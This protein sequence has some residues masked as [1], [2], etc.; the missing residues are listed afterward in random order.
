MLSDPEDEEDDSQ[1]LLK[2]QRVQSSVV[3][4][5][6]EGKK[7]SCLSVH[8][9]YLAIGFQTGEVN[10]SDF[11]GKVSR[12]LKPHS[13]AVTGLSIDAS[14]D[15]LAST[16]RDGSLVVNSLQP[17]EST[18]E[19]AAADVYKYSKPM[20]VVHLDPAYARRRDKLLLTGGEAGQLVL[21]KKGWFSQKQQV[22]YEG[23]GP[24]TT[25]AWRGAL[26]AWCNALGAKIIDVGSGDRISYVDRPKGGGGST[27]CLHWET[28]TRLLLGWSDT[29]MLLQVTGS[30]TGFGSKG[31]GARQRAAEIVVM[32]Q[33]DM[34]IRG[35]S[36]FQADSLV[37][38]GCNSGESQDPLVL[39]QPEVHVV[40]RATGE[41]LSADVLPLKGWDGE[42]QGQQLMME[43]TCLSTASLRTPADQLPTEMAALG[44][45]PA[46]FISCATDMVVARA[47]DTDD[48]VAWAMSRGDLEGAVMCALTSKHSLY[49]YD[50]QELLRQHLDCLLDEER[51]M[52]AAMQC[53]SMLG[54]NSLAW[55]RWVGVFIERGHLD[56]IVPHVPVSSPKLPQKLYTAILVQLLKASPRRQPQ[57]LLDT[58]RRWALLQ[59]RGIR[60]GEW[61]FDYDAVEAKLEEAL[62][63]HMDPVLLEVQAE[64]C[65]MDRQFEK[66]LGIYFKVADVMAKSPSQP[67]EDGQG[68]RDYQQVFRIIAQQSLF[69]VV[70]PHVAKLITLS[71]KLAGDMLVRHVDQLP[72]ASVVALLQDKRDLQHWYLHML[73]TQCPEVYNTPE[74]ARFHLLQVWLYGEFA[75]PFEPQ[76]KAP[77]TSDF[78]NFLRGSNFAPLEPAL[79]ACKQRKPPLYDEI[80]YILG[81]LGDTKGALLIL[82]EQIR[83]V[84][85]AVEFVEVQHANVL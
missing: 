84:P 13:L 24:I 55:E 39:W 62:A 53:S 65:I 10:L 20:R 12:R 31:R 43:S 61:I 19:W 40:A 82:L 79:Q 47:R 81:R 14:G 64:L 36:P 16:S 71:R 70:Q 38:L 25:I 41:V 4:L 44:L 18:A 34:S 3:K 33:A 1:P 32:W 52:E 78:M 80:V 56:A 15:Y 59:P 5:L 35:I 2:Y 27:P 76:Q 67:L 45:P 74:Y 28:D 30:G 73:F 21:V 60:R 63:V 26:A 23:E 29:V 7:I 77:Y 8:G 17:D 75:P 37:L 58:V 51:Y 22:L 48:Q 54:E 68:P 69:S 11:H 6:D 42:G 83:S 66:A 57:L 50:F 85:R 9:D 72:V 46:L 49:S